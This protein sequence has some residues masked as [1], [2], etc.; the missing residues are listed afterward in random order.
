MKNRYKALILIGSLFVF[1]YL[2]YI[3]YNEAKEHAIS[4][5]VSREQILA[6]QAKNEIE[7]FFSNTYQFLEP[8]TQSEHIII[9]NDTGKKEMDLAFS[10]RPEGIKAITR[11]SEAG[12]IIYTIPENTSVINSDISHQAHV[13]KILKTHKPVVSDVFPAV[14][15][16]R[17]IALH[18]PVFHGDE[19]HG[20]MAILIDFF[21]ISK[22]SL[23][24]IRI[25]E[26]GYAWMTSQNGIELYC[27]VSGHTGNS[28]FQN[29]K[30][31]PSV[32]RMA[33]KMVAGQSGVTRYHFDQIKNRHLK[34]IEKHAVFLRINIFDTFW[35]I[36][37]ASSENE[38]LQTLVGFKNKLIIIIGFLLIFS[39]TFSY[40]SV[41]AWAIVREAGERKKAQEMLRRSEERYREIVEGTENLVTEVDV[42]GKITF[43]NEAS[44]KIFGISPKE[45]IGRLAF[46]FIHPDDQEMTQQNFVKW[47]ER[48]DTSA[49]FEN[50]QVSQS[51]QIRDMLWTIKIHYNENGEITSLKS[52]AR[53]ITERKKVEKELQLSNARFKQI[54][55]SETVGIVLATLDGRIIEANDAFLILTGY[56]RDQL[57]LDWV[58]MT[59]PKWIDQDK[60]IVQQIKNSDVVP[61]YEKELLCAD[62]RHLPVMIAGVQLKEEG[63]KVLAFFLDLTEKKKADEDLKHSQATLASI[64]TAAPVGIGMVMDR[65]IT[66]VNDQLIQISGYSREE[67]IG[68]SA[69]MLYPSTEEFEHV[70]KTKYDQIRLYG[71][72]TLETHWKKKN[73]EIINVLLSSTPL[74]I[75]DLSAG[76]TFTALDMTKRKQ[77]EIKL[78]KSEAF[79]AA[80]ISSIQD[81]LS[82][83][84]RELTIQKVNPMMESWYKDQ[85]PLEGKK[86][87]TCYRSNNVPCDPCPSLRAIESGKTESNIIPGPAGSDIEWLEVFS[88]PILYP[89]SNAVT[90]VVE[91]ARD[92][93]K[94]VRSEKELETHRGHLEDLVQE[95][96]AELQTTNRALE[97]AK[98]E[99]EKAN[100]AKSEFLANMSHEIRTPLNAVCQSASKN[101]PLSAPNFDPSKVKKNII[102]CSLIS[103]YHSLFL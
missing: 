23:Q 101:D 39:F 29:C 94:R 67:L 64:F 82:V 79:L 12:R 81:G 74:D 16:Y 62:G 37:V 89:E 76:V 84:D 47:L 88:Y 45:C 72:G 102:F 103:N 8:L 83:L 57:P 75:N 24:N 7:L 56:H 95:R 99:A 33:E 41:K 46:D 38:V 93:T 54:F 9:F 59:P 60:S 92:I 36:V 6:Q 13:K 15:G 52:I 44:H 86:C 18:I 1:S 48:G 35:T 30:D 50:R 31:Y 55:K 97:E 28:V 61:T 80:T 85:M 73:G 3:T 5:L 49:T 58:A 27:P 40:Y 14:Q 19:F 26:T 87:Y 10:L 17:A 96:T 91:F 65:V 43:V 11:I 51:G 25:G 53:D 66:Y 90:G 2:F 34:N 63:H 32:I 20:S 4:D 71:T 21:S 98:M 70:G 22:R 77:A 100:L 69:L 42:K 78:K 68:K